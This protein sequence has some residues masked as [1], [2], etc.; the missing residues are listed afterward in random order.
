MGKPTAVNTRRR[1]LNSSISFVPQ[2]I[3][4]SIRTATRFQPKLVRFRR[5]VVSPLSDLSSGAVGVIVHV[6]D[7]PE[8]IYAQLRAQNIR[9]GQRVTVLEKSSRRIRIENDGEE[10]VM[11]PVVAA[12]VCVQPLPEAA[13]VECVDRLSS[14][15]VGES[16]KVVGLSSACQGPERRRLLDFRPVAR[17]G[18]HGGDAKSDS[19]PHR[20]SHSW[21]GH[22]AAS[23][24]G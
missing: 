2:V 10:Q 5:A 14:L 9:I 6:E 18:S 15:K 12:N 1:Q 24:T 13:P 23:Q 16:R 17:H 8:A 3:H 21:S 20:L 4:A 7:E 19:R 22:R 11:A